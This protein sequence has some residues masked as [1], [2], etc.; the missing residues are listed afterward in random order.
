M[1]Q[2]Q[3]WNL[4]ATP[5]LWGI[6]R[7]FD[8]K[9]SVSLLWMIRA[10]CIAYWPK[11]AVIDSG[12]DTMVCSDSGYERDPVTEEFTGVCTDVLF[13]SRHQDLNH[14]ANKSNNCS[15]GINQGISLDPTSEVRQIRNYRYSTSAREMMTGMGTATTAF[16]EE[17]PS[18]YRFSDDYQD[19]AL[20]K[21][22]ATAVT[23]VI[24]GDPYSYSK[25]RRRPRSVEL[26]P[27]R[28]GFSG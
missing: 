27:R 16:W 9:V 12:L 19:D 10:N 26:R 13:H 4:T 2:P 17:I 8:R 28:V 15:G 5:T 23:S 1:G 24:A 6:K 11:V 3:L 18:S 7:G 22:H 20:Y 14:L 21:G 25:R